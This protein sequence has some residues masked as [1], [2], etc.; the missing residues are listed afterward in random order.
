MATGCPGA[1]ERPGGRWVVRPRRSTAGGFRGRRE[2]RI[3]IYRCIESYGYLEEYGRLEDCR[4]RKGSSACGSD[5]L[6]GTAG[7]HHVVGKKLAA[8]RAAGEYRRPEPG[9]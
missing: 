5:A 9:L 7:V 1:G 2:G 4:R 3:E 6:L 8:A